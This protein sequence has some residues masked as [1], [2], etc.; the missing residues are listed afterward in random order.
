MIAEVRAGKR[1]GS[2]ISTKMFNS[3]TQN[4]RETWEALHRELEDIGISPAVITEKRQFIIAWFQEAVA[5][6]RLEED[7]P[8][9]D[10]DDDDNSKAGLSS[11]SCDTKS[12]TDLN[13]HHHDNGLSPIS[14]SA[15]PAGAAGVRYG[16]RIEELPVGGMTKNGQVAMPPTPPHRYGSFHADSSGAEEYTGDDGINPWRRH[17]SR[18]AVFP[19]ASS[20]TCN[21]NSDSNIDHSMSTM[22]LE[23]RETE[24]STVERSVAKT[25][26]SSEQLG[27]ASHSI[28]GPQSSSTLPEKKKKSRLRISYL[29]SK[30]GSKDN[31]LFEAATI[32]D[33]ATIKT[34]LEHVFDIESKDKYAHTALLC[35][36]VHGH[37]AVVQLLL[38]KGADIE[39]KTKIG[40][41]ALACASEHGHVAVVQLLL[42]KGADIE[43]K[44]KIGN[45]ALAC[46]SE[47]GHVAVVQ[48]LLDKGAEIESKTQLGYTALACASKHGHVAVV[49]LLLNKG[50]DIESRNR[51]G[52]TALQ[53]ASSSGHVAVVQLLLDNGAMVDTA[54]A[55]GR[56]AL[57]YAEQFHKEA[58]A[59]LLRRAGAR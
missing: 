15:H 33:V 16:N 59:R 51:Y 36:S 50:A 18:D 24:A 27:R 52:T 9:D 58:V 47:H 4:D 45:T 53:Y 57:S 21:S 41:T 32:G 44:T 10:D 56:T 46:A 38:N 25:Q 34:L 1:E 29:L 8:S 20:Q 37:V 43:S 11:I 49:Q 35:A 48:L 54:N 31:R 7:S 13:H 23:R 28:R 40:N 17:A 42:N 2:V 19:L 14:A 5:A 55:N 39:S 26:R 3:S 30:L 6:G 12:L 22:T